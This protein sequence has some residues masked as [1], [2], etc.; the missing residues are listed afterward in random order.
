MIN[1]QFFLMLDT[2]GNMI[3]SKDAATT[4]INEEMYC[5]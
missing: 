3:Y 5:K 2:D 4:E 1:M